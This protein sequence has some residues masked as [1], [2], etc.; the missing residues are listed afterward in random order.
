MNLKNEPQIVYIDDI[1]EFSNIYHYNNIVSMKSSSNYNLLS[2]SQKSLLFMHNRNVVS[3]SVEYP[4]INYNYFIDLSNYDVNKIECIEVSHQEL[5][6]DKL[7]FTNLYLI[8][9]MS[10]L[11]LPKNSYPLP[12][13]FTDEI[14]NYATLHL[15]YNNN[16]YVIIP[17][18][19]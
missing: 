2:N 10:H 14:V 3:S 11:N 7:F 12:E 8:K 9:E 16:K 15:V 13:Y 5:L 6:I 18:K 17:I 19:K 1:S 4:T